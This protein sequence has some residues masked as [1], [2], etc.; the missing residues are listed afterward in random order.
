MYWTNDYIY[1]YIYIYIYTYIHTYINYGFLTTIAAVQSVELKYDD[2][3]KDI[4]SKNL[5]SLYMIMERGEIAHCET[6]ETNFPEI[7]ERRS[8]WKF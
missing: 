7:Y 5:L 8:E 6:M 4:W 1:I 3:W 2:S